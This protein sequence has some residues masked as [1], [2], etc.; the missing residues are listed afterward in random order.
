[1]WVDG[2][3]RG[4]FGE[5][6]GVFGGA[7]VPTLLPLRLG[8]FFSF[9]TPSLSF[10][11]YFLP[12]FPFLIMTLFSFRALFSL[13]F[14]LPFFLRL[15]FPSPSLFLDA[16]LP[17]LFPLF[18]PL[19]RLPIGAPD[20]L[21][22]AP[23]ASSPRWCSFYSRISGFPSA[24]VTRSLLSFL[25]A[26]SLFISAFISAFFPLFRLPIGGEAVSSRWP[27]WGTSNLF[28]FAYASSSTL[29]FVRPLHFVPHTASLLPGLLRWLL[30]RSPQP[31]YLR[32]LRG[33]PRQHTACPGAGRLCR[34]VSSVRFDVP[35]AFSSFLRRLST[36]LSPR[37]RRSFIAPCYPSRPFLDR[38]TGARFI[39][40]ICAV[41]LRLFPHFFPS[42]SSLSNSLLPVLFA[43]LSFIK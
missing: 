30:S 26:V 2:L 38:F 31:S 39:F 17:F 19:F 24:S 41:G 3:F 42:F 10:L 15:R 14:P 21:L 43:H 8:F 35:H 11:P 33:G 28:P 32:S 12:L 23:S 5:G 22:F 36:G 4:F 7:S 20:Y 27:F 1:M 37:F 18:F 16:L 34:R 13:S 29:R 25:S 6:Y 40:F 9:F